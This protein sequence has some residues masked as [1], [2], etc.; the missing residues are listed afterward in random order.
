MEVRD[1]RTEF[2]GAR[3]SVTAVD[4]V[5]FTVDAGEMVALV[6]ESGCGKSATAQSIMGLIVP[7]A[8]QV[9]GGQVLFEGRDLLKLSARDLRAVRGKGISMIFQDPMTSLN[10][11]LTVGRQMTEALELHLGMSRRA[12][13]KRAVELL[14]MVRIPAAETRLSSYPHQLSGG[15]RQRVMIAMALSCRPRLILADEITTALDVTIQAQVLDLLRELALETRTA[16]LF[17]THDLG[18]VAGM[19]ER[20]NVMYAGQIV[21]RAGTVDL[22][23]QPQMPYTWGLLGSVP[24]LDQA[25][26]GKLRPIAGRPPELSEIPPGCR[27]APRCVHARDVCQDQAPGLT[28][29]PARDQLTRCWG[30]RPADQGGWLTT[31]DRFA[32]QSAEVR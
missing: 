15:M 3:G 24:R 19:A 31:E 1:L 18:V 25:R 2:R 32:D 6:G 28:T 17:I 10:P 12:A 20:V 11:V 27:F 30:M 13:R 4:G 21:E 29:V 16:V 23:H 22:F 7:P 14:D 5:S 9:T 26:G 8:G